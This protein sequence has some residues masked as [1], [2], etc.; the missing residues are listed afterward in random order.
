MG[1]AARDEVSLKKKIPEGCSRRARSTLTKTTPKTRVFGEEWPQSFGRIRLRCLYC[2]AGRSR[3]LKIRATHPEHRA[4]PSVQVRKYPRELL[5]LGE[6]PQCA[7]PGFTGPAGERSRAPGSGRA[8]ARPAAAEVR[9]LPDLERSFPSSSGR[10]R[11]PP[12]AAHPGNGVNSYY[13][14]IYFLISL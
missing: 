6:R 14:Y 8:F 5:T 3:Y 7:Y 2:P 11:A 12:P 1:R 9:I 4:A 13:L 10:A